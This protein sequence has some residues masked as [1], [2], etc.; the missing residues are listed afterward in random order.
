MFA[1]FAAGIVEL[2]LLRFSSGDVYPVYSSLRGDPLGVKALYESLEQCCGLRVSRNYEPFENIKNRTEAVL[3][4]SGE[5]PPLQDFLP[6]VFV[7]DLEFFLRNGGRIVVTYALDSETNIESIRERQKKE[8]E[9]KDKEE[10]DE[11]KKKK[12]EEMKKKVEEEEQHLVSFTKR[13]GLQ[14]RQ[15]PLEGATEARLTEEFAG[16]GLP[17]L[18]YWHSSLYFDQLD[19]AWHVVYK[20]EG[21]PVVIERRMGKGTVILSADSYFLSNEAMLRNRYPELLAWLIGGKN[22]VIFDEYFHGIAANPGVAALARRYRLHGL[23]AGILTLVGLFIWK[24]SISFVPPHPDSGGSRNGYAAEGKDSAAGL[25][26]LL[27]RSIPAKEILTVCWQEWKKS[28]AQTVA[29]TKNQLER[30]ESEYQ[31]ERSASLRQ[32]DPAQAY[33]KIS[34]ILKER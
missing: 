11:S 12:K 21:K 17:Q 14:Y 13:W 3:V 29:R 33:N 7:E 23:I 24:N 27:R 8:K 34:R 5:Y 6:V 9:K 2:L 26:N 28:H 1:V 22:T 32:R 30:M 10:D 18:V 15:Y 19:P 31:A 16:A 4:F 25:T 20:R